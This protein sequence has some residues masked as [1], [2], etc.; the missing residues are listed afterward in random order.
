[1]DVVRQT[2]DERAAN[3]E[4]DGVSARVRQPNFLARA[5]GGNTNNNKGG[6]PANQATA[7]RQ[8]TFGS[9]GLHARM[10]GGSATLAR[11]GSECLGS[12]G[13]EGGWG[14]GRGHGGRT[15]VVG[16]LKGGG[17]TTGPM[18]MVRFEG[19]RLHKPQDK[20]HAA[21]R[22]C[23]SGNARARDAPKTKTG[24]E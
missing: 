23:I 21:R 6:S 1:V 12:G 15:R 14:G 2:K 13:E 22:R 7:R 20:A 10:R 5:Q 9:H 24:R 19:A 8:P 16:C 17:F 3:D 11:L 4:P 18:T